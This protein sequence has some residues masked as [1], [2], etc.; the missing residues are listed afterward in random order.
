MGRQE[1]FDVAVVGGGPAGLTAAYHAAGHGVRV[2][3]VDR[4]VVP[5]EKIAI[6]GGG[7]CNILPTTVDPAA[8]V[9]DSSKHTLRKMLLSWPLDE[10]RAF[11]ERD[12]GLR[13][14]REAGTGKFFPARGGGAE[15]RRRLLLAVQDS[16]VRLD[17]KTLV[18]GIYPGAPHRVRIEDGT[19]IG[20]HCVI[21]ATGGLSY[22]RTGS[23]GTGFEI[24][25][26]L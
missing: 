5:G 25:R 21:V 17:T 6:S 12:I 24:A 1:T 4:K 18:T 3:L 19:S 2:V 15:V 7:R 16:G 26:Q 11:L 13:L 10:V 22:R 14:R 8:Y 23:D 20:A 9:T